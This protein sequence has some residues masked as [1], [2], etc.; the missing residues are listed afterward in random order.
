MRRLCTKEDWFKCS[1]SSPLIFLVLKN[2]ICNLSIELNSVSVLLVLHVKCIITNVWI[3]RQVGSVEQLGK[4]A[5]ATGRQWECTLTN[6]VAVIC[7]SVESINPSNAFEYSLASSLDKSNL[8]L[9]TSMRGEARGFH[10]AG[11]MSECSTC[12][13]DVGNRRTLLIDV[14]GYRHG[15][16]TLTIA[17][18]PRDTWTSFGETIIYF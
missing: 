1:W 10:V 7:R 17:R 8:E 3:K 9:S 4:A 16:L 12:Q 5:W 13:Y 15:R 18:Q 2:K 11:I 6:S 14:V